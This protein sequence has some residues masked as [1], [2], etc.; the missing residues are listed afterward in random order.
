MEAQIKYS[1]RQQDY[2][3][4][5]EVKAMCAKRQC[6]FKDHEL[7]R[8]LPATVFHDYLYCRR[9]FFER[10]VRENQEHI[11]QGVQDEMARRLAMASD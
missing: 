8:L 7:A 4:A 9:K 3:G 1:L 10:L 2:L 5:I 6:T 11:R